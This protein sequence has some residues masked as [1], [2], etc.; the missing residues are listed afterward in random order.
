MSLFNPPFNNS[1]LLVIAYFPI[2]IP[3]LDFFVAFC[4]TGYRASKVAEFGDLFYFFS[5]DCNLLFS[6]SSL[7][8]LPCLS[9]LPLFR[10]SGTC[11]NSNLYENYSKLGLFNLLC[12]ISA[13]SVFIAIDK[14]NKNISINEGLCMNVCVCLV[15]LYS[16]TIRPSLNKL[17]SKPVFIYFRNLFLLNEES[18]AYR[19]TTQ[20]NIPKL[21]PN[22]LGLLFT[23][24]PIRS[25]SIFLT[26]TILYALWCILVKVCKSLHTHR[27][28]GPLLPG[29][30][31]KNSLID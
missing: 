5:I 2:A 22:H 26:Q 12:S 9:S 8:L 3:F 24:Q 13:L 1:F 7:L 18:T 20:S 31:G 11:P 17:H 14:W 27:V 23:M 28:T 21:G 25:T 6:Y 15:G 4:I 19:P 29:S 10:R 16:I 30:I